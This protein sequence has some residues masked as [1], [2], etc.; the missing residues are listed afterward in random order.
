MESVRGLF[1]QLL[2]AKSITWED[3]ELLRECGCWR[4]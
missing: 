2:E 3:L 4:I 1:L